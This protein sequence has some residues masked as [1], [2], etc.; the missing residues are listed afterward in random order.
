MMVV[1]DAGLIHDRQGWQDDTVL[2][3][4]YTLLVV[5]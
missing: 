1:G 2:G 4:I 3:R 5:L